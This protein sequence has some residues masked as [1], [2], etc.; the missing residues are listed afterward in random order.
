[1]LSPLYIKF[2]LTLVNKSLSHS[3][4]GLMAHLPVR[5]RYAPVLPSFRLM[6][7]NSCHLKIALVASHNGMGHTS[8]L[9][10]LMASLEK[11]GH[12]SFV[13]TGPRQFEVLEQSASSTRSVR[14]LGSLQAEWL[15]GPHVQT[16][17]VTNLTLE[18]EPELSSVRDADL[19][20]SDNVT[21]PV[22]WNDNVVLL[23]HFTWA[24]YFGKKVRVSFPSELDRLER[25]K[26]LISPKHFSIPSAHISSL[27]RTVCKLPIFE[28]FQAL[29]PMLPRREIW[30]TSGITQSNLVS[31]ESLI[32]NI[33]PDMPIMQHETFEMERLGAKPL[34]FIGRP[35]MAS[36]NEALSAGVSYWP[37]YLGRDPE[38]DR[39]AATL[40]KLGISSKISLDGRHLADATKSLNGSVREAQNYGAREMQPVV[41]WASQIV[42]L[43]LGIL[44]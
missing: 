24:D 42:T 23:S 7:L 10:K 6:R 13:L 3:K 17:R 26:L 5:E 19:V 21:W 34:V 30:L 15:D 2:S 31:R 4:Y 41:S 39:N 12:S 36:I 44:P 1:M 20:I 11:L 25:V 9:I 33:G 8:R 16:P 40:S 14:V 35:G 32:E 43:S 38:L 22:E 18:R 37:A 29:R 27:K 28:E